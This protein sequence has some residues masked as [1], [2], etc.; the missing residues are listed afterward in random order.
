LEEIRELVINEDEYREFLKERLRLKNDQCFA[1]IEKVGFPFLFAS[2]SELL[3]T[4]ILNESEFVQNLPDNLKLPDRG[5]LWYMFAQSVREIHVNPEKVVITYQL[6]ES[7][8]LPFK[9]FYM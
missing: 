4:Y 3:R 5:Y 6:L 7:Y 9:R 8:K 2:G 1:E